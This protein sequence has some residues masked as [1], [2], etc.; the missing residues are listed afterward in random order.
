MSAK[1]APPTQSAETEVQETDFIDAEFTA[2]DFAATESVDEAPEAETF[3]LIALDLQPT[4]ALSVIEAQA[5]DSHPALVYLARLAPGSRR[6]MS[7]ALT[8]IAGKVS[9]G[10]S[11]LWTLAWHEL[12]YQHTAA[13]RSVLAEQYAP[14]TVNKMLAALRGT[15]KE[16]W[17]LGL[18]SA[19]DFHRAADLPAV[20]GSV[21][22]RGRALSAGELRALLQICAQDRATAGRRD[23]A[24]ATTL[25]GAG[26]RRSEAMALE[27]RDYGVETGALTVRSGKGRKDR[28]AY[29]P[30][31]CRA[32][33]EAWLSAR[34]PEA[35][36]LFV[37][38]NK[39]GKLA[40]RVMSDQAVL[41]I[42]RKRAR[43][44]GLAAFSPHDLRR[45]FIGDLL[46]AGAD[47]ATVQQMAGHAN[48]QTTVRYDRRGEGVKKKVAEL[49]HV[50]F[51]S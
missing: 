26:L 31:G 11:T 7:E 19:E 9:A 8:V 44:A 18:V 20:R 50:P 30:S 3:P 43:E 35:G 21:L 16:C 36:P 45:T 15:L 41:Y 48:V 33:L 13:L 1:S 12:R 22:P 42:L 46:D 34:G 24:L 47:I 40:L 6:T 17:R 4:A 5:S 39:A 49:L 38:I 32:A 29:A 25:Y 14:A 10:H 23:G 2:A 28:M 27:V 37:P 51:G